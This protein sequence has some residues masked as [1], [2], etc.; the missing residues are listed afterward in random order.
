MDIFFN[1]FF[2]QAWKSHWKKEKEKNNFFG[3]V[4]KMCYI[5]MLL[6]KM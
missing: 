6:A 3:K 2:F 1:V 5:H 4:M